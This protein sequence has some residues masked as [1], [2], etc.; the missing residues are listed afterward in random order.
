MRD[1]YLLMHLAIL[2]W[3][4]TGIFGKA[5]E[6]SEGM[7]V[8]FRMIISA[9]GLL[10]FMIKS[11]FKV[12]GRKDFIHISF[13]GGLVALHWVLFYASIKASNV[14]IALSCFST[15]SLFT[16]IMDPIMRNQRIK[17]PEILLSLAVIA[18]LYIIYTVRQAYLLGI[19]LAIA[20]A[21]VGSLFTIY[22]KKLTEKHPAVDI[23]FYE[24][25]TGFVLLSALLPS[26]FS[27]TDT[28]FQW[29]SS[30]DWI[31]LVLLSILC[32]SVA[33]TISIKA[34]KKLDPF[35]MNLSVNLEPLYSIVLAWFFFNEN[36]MMTSGFMAGTIV[37]LA[38]VVVH[39]RYKWV[40]KRT[41][42]TLVD[43]NA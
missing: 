19:I 15:V 43:E 10:P 13:V 26:Y 25:A 21:F 18:G 41:E 34:L 42:A 12:P 31:W 14:S 36:E 22:N 7:I 5:I 23:T 32:T 40:K 39:T 24:L 3:G 20:S 8:W 27:F 37:I 6:M 4:F 35:T 38:S 28:G 16:A 17:L 9:L 11:G 29:P 2:L 1:A 33:F 30:T